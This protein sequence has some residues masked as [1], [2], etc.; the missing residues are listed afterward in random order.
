MPSAEQLYELVMRDARED[1]FLVAVRRAIDTRLIKVEF[2]A[3]RGPGPHEVHALTI[4]VP[5][6]GL[7]VSKEGIPHDWLPISTGFIDTR[8]SRLV[9]SL[10]GELADKAQRAGVFL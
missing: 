1:I 2:D 9:E 5:D 3:G 8:F 4:S 7:A 10:L 6:V